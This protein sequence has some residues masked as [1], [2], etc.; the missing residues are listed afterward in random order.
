MSRVLTM[1]RFLASPPVWA[2]RQRGFGAMLAA[3]ALCAALCT[4]LAWVRLPTVGVGDAAQ[5]E[6]SRLA[7]EAAGVIRL[8]RVQKGIAVDPELDPAGGGL[9]G[10]D[11]T[12]LTSTVGSLSAKRTSQNPDFAA[13][14]VLLLEEAGVRRGDAV[15]L[16][17]SG[18]FPALNIAVL[19][20]CK[21]MGLEAR[22]VSSLGA[23][24]YGANIPG[25]TWAEMENALFEAGVF[26]YKSVAMSLGG[27]VDTGGGIDGTGIELALASITA[28][29]VPC[30]PEGERDQLEADILRRR[31]I[32]Y[33]GG[34]PAAFIN[35]G[36]NITALGWVAE[37]ALLDNGL[38]RQVPAVSSPQRGLVF[39]MYEDGVPVIHLLNINRLA[40]RYGLPVS[41]AVLP[42]PGTSLGMELE[43]GLYGSALLAGLWVLFSM[44]AFVYGGVPRAGS[45]GLVMAKK[46]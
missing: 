15:A 26:P 8:E 11:Y 37:A 14:V 27:I 33:S 45:N 44:L 29:G 1:F 24:S 5:L 4:A 36:G 25:F 43:K 9:I 22:L 18:S 23:S 38:L 42:E 7:A 16:S 31:N 12:D 20:A 3:G 17:F 30:L 28:A 19:A 39:R 41:P 10:A 2:A 21:S 13:L 32:Y 46:A 35:V 6:A 40:A 34:K